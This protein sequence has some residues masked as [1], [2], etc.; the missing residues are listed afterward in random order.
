MKKISNYILVFCALILVSSC[1][2][3]LDR[4]QQS[5]LP[6][7]DI[8]KDFVHAQ[9]FVEVMYRYVVNQA[10]SGNQNDGSNFLL[11]EEV[12]SANSGMLPYRFDMGNMEFAVSVQGSLSV[13]NNLGGLGYFDRPDMNGSTPS[14]EH[15]YPT[16]RPGIWDGWK[17]IRIANIVLDNMHLMTGASET[18]KNLIKGQALFFRAYFHSEIMKYWGRIPYVD[19][20]ITGNNDDYKLRRPDTYKECAMKADADY[21]AAAALLPNNW[22]DLKDDPTA[23]LYTF[24]TE[25]FGN[26]L[27]RINKAIVYSFKG[28]NLLMAAS[29]LMKNSTSATPPD[30]YDYD[31]E[32][33]ELAAADFARV[34]QMDRD[35]VN[36]L[37]LATA[38]NYYRLFYTDATSIG[39]LQWPGTAINMGSG[40]GE[41]IFSSTAAALNFT[42]AQA[43]AYM[44]Y[45]NKINPVRPTHRYINRTFGTANGLACSEDPT[46]DPQKEFE[47]RDPRFYINHIVDGDTIIR[48]MG[49]STKYKYA[50]LYTTGESRKINSVENFETGYF[51]KKWADITFNNATTSG[52]PPSDNPDNITNF[53]S[54][55]MNMR[56]ADVYL[57]YAE[58]LAATT[59]Y[60]VATAPNFSH[61]PG[62]PS[63]I[64]VINMLRARFG[65]QTV[66][67]AYQ[68]IG[69]NILGDRNRFLDV[70]RRER[71]IE[72]AYEGHRWDDIRRWV[73]AHLPDYKTKS[74]IDFER[75][76]YAETARGNFRNVNFN[77]RI[78]RTRVC[79]YPKHYWIPFTTKQT[80]MFEGFPQNPGW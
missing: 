57:M 52:M 74:A 60:G 39:R 56:L 55:R 51:I 19:F 53:N 59:K 76:T 48:N 72:L 3:Y 43:S 10:N 20:V 67:A 5:E 66:Q 31:Q 70:V 77:E 30:T 16:V 24:K 38:A 58:A 8:F 49:A 15:D 25:T 44:P 79:E 80:E 18:E 6:V 47:N 71:S 41:Y 37:G 78:I 64:E 11:A 63:A 4:P 45:T 21:A 29:P 33:C 50:Q 61:L 12:I 2:D 35:N 46:Y 42:R 13:N 40:E 62:A 22:D 54:F 73:L 14:W 17:A 28:K 9:G 75:D 1:E 7:E 65:I 69:V 27:M 32:L 36:N 23:K 34:I 68:S 26:N